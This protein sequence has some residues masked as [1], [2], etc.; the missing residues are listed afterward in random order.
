MIFE[1]D[2]GK[3]KG[4][5]V[6]IVF[7]G[8]GEIGRRACGVVDILGIEPDYFTDNAEDLGEHECCG[9]KIISVEVA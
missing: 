3:R 7:F 8:A 4:I 5:I 9:V 2:R 6:E 1:R